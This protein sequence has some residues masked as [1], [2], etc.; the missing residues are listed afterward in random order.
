MIT[1]PTGAD[2]PIRLGIVG[3]GRWGRNIIKTVASLPLVELAGVV[4]SN[5][6]TQGLVPTDCPV[7]TDWREFIAR[8]PMDGI[9]IATPPATHCAIAQASIVAGLHTLIEKPLSLN[10]EEAENILAL[11]RHHNR[12][13]M[14]E[15]TQLFNPKFRTLMTSLP[16]LKGIRFILTRAG[17]FGP[18][19]TDTPVLW[20]WGA[21]ELSMLMTLT[22]S[23]PLSISAQRVAKGKGTQG[24]ESIWKVDC[25]FASGVRSETVLGNMMPRCR[26]IAVIGVTGALVFDDVGETPLSY[27]PGHHLFEFPERSGEKLLVADTTTPLAQAILEFAT[28]IRC[29]R[30]SDE[31]AQLGVEVVRQLSFCTRSG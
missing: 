31:S 27:Y 15:F 11:A 17:N 2:R 1:R 20:D 18:F 9:V 19:R 7:V 8:I 26:K 23:A 10:L 29:D 24:E 21:H 14:T 5:P 25:S 30:I 6:T 13:A 3:A 28:A 4:S 22:A 12:L 16:M